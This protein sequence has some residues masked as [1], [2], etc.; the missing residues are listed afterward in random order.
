MHSASTSSAAP[1]KSSLSNSNPSGPVKRSASVA[2]SAPQS[3]PPAAPLDALA[4]QDLSPKLHGKRG[5]ASR[6]RSSVAHAALEGV[7]TIKE[8]VGNLHRWSQ[9]T[10][11]SAASV[12]KP[13]QG[14]FSRRLSFTGPSPFANFHGS[15]LHSP[16]RRS[17][18]RTRSPDVSPRGGQGRPYSPPNIPPPTTSPPAVPI[19]PATVFDPRPHSPSTAPPSNAGGLFTPPVAFGGPDYFSSRPPVASNASPRRQRA[20]SQQQGPSVRSPLGSPAPLENRAYKPN[21]PL[22]SASASI[23]QRPRQGSVDTTRFRQGSVDHRSASAIGNRSKESRDYNTSR[24]AKERSDSDA[25]RKSE[26]EATRTQ[27]RNKERGD[28]DK[29]TMLSRAL[30]KANTAVLLDNAQNFEGAMEAYG[31]ACRLLQQVMI[32]SHGE[33]DRRKLEA[34][35]VTYTN[36]IQELKLLD[37]SWQSASG[38][39]LPARPLSEHSLGG[40]AQADEPAEYEEPMVIET[41]TIT[42]IVN[43]KSVE[44][45]H[46]QPSFK[47]R[48]GARES[49]ISSAIRDVESSMSHASDSNFFLQAPHGKQ[50]NNAQGSERADDDQSYMPPPLSPRRTLSPNTS[51]DPYD[52][53][54]SNSQAGNHQR[55]NSH[56]SISWLDTIDESGGSS[57]A[58]SVHS[59][60]Y[61]G[62][63]RRHLRL[64]SGATEAEF[65]AALDAAVEA[66]Y[67]DPLDPFDDEDPIRKAE[68]VAEHRRNVELAR[69]RVRDAEREATI[70]A[71]VQHDRDMRLGGGSI[72]LGPQDEEAEDEERMLEEMTK[73]YMLDGFDFDLNSKSALPRQSDSSGFSGTS[74][75]HSS[76]SSARNTAGTS[77]STVAEAP[78][79][80]PPS[81]PLPPVTEQESPTAAPR[82]PTAAHSATGS[83]GS[84]SVRSRRLSG[85]NAKQ[86]KIETSVNLPPKDTAPLTQPYMLK[87]DETPDMP[88]TAA[89]AFKVPSAPASQSNLRVASAQ[90]AGASPADSMPS[91]SPATSLN[92]ILSNDGTAVDPGRSMFPGKGGIQPPQLKK[93][94]SSMSLRNRQM[95][96]SSPDGSDGSVGTPLS[97]TFSTFTGRK[98]S[99]PH[100]APTPSLPTFTL[101]GMGIPTGG[102]HLFESDIHS[103]H[104]PGSPNPLAI[105]APIPL[106]PC[107]EG[108]LLRPFWLMRCFYQTLAHPRGGY[109]STKLFV[110]RD[111]WSVK[112]VKIKNLEEKISNCDL[113]T[114]ALLKLSSVDTFDADAVLEEMQALE[115]VLDQVQ[116]NLVKKLGSEVGTN[117]ATA[118]FKDAHTVGV[119]S[120]DGS[121]A[122]ELPS[123]SGTGRSYLTSWKKLRSKNSGANLANTFTGAKDISKD[124]LTMNTLPM[125]SLPNVRMAK[126]EISQVDFT[127]PHANYMSALAKLFDAVQI[128][129]QIARQVEDPGL[130]HSSPTHVGLELS[131]RHAAEFFGFYVCRFV[132]TD[133]AM[134]LDKFIKRGSEWVLV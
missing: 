57:C 46:P 121:T 28:K 25:S 22:H 7:N 81:G 125:T 107:P 19:L 61:G 102:M 43:D 111:M 84:S 69:E 53:E 47:A 108:Y 31:D 134:M 1:A 120:P 33:D 79:L 17:P 52:D 119:T 18:T 50:E 65:D 8:G 96:I 3:R 101:D 38:K 131:T 118:M 58:S 16:P 73:E 23:S 49:V 56:E 93:N 36:R 76:T 83:I 6:R 82:P 88:K 104:S 97:T 70:Q 48:A 39:T 30:Q 51:G 37:P 85:Q 92:Q 91:I 9:S 32:R 127:G 95:S 122:P 77:L 94:K 21:K 72:D 26:D 75:W 13:A 41:A 112:G 78:T 100:I 60:S 42:R 20:P 63:H 24:R 105:N 132:L 114:A 5:S 54:R 59:M 10:T 98:A 27:S 71:A 67:D 11:S 64:G 90:S 45:E 130:K 110:P 86:L 123:K 62:V 4:E 103:P 14:S 89:A 116:T 55:D 68:I 113:L 44:P 128:I 87:V 12:E 133:V 99:V 129:D 124:S 29:K 15:N 2:S 126:R 117:G 115:A 34:I 35:R 66:A 109:L 80:P 106:E 74:T 40:D